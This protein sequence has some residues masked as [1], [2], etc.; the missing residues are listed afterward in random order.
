M[1]H[2]QCIRSSRV[3]GIVNRQS[4][5]SEK[6]MLEIKMFRGVFINLFLKN[7]LLIELYDFFLIDLRQAIMMETFWTKPPIMII[8]YRNIST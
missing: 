5:M 8:T 1:G 3:R 7:N 2:H 4:K 6:A